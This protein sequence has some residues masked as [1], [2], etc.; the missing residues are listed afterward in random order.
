MFKKILMFTVLF[1]VCAMAQAQ[2]QRINV[3]AFTGSESVS[4][5]NVE[6]VRAAVISAVNASQRFDLLDDAA[7]ASIEE[8]LV[9]RSSEEA[10]NDA[11]ARKALIAIKAN[12][13]LM[14]GNVASLEIKK[15]EKE[16]KIFYAAALN[17][18]VSVTDVAGN[19]TVATKSFSRE[20]TN[21][22]VGGGSIAGLTDAVLNNDTP[23]K[24]V[25]E[26][27]TTIDGDIKKFF[28]E[29]F[30]LLATIYGEDFEIKKDKLVQCYISIGTN[31]GVFNGQMF[32]IFEVKI[33]VGKE[34]KSKIG[35]LKIVQADEDIA[36][37]K[38]TKGDKEVKLAMDRYLENKAV[39]ENATPLIVIS[40]PKKDPLGLGGMAKGL[41]L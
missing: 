27:L 7:W 9:R 19:K 18:S 29:E 21:V 17:Y 39:D 5:E 16:G 4:A 6:K 15:E 37:G 33:K 23:E 3:K 8:E 12:N 14:T 35:S 11:E 32:D 26:V 28:E 40:R 24:A 41:G 2:K 36:L 34:T 38:V 1:A 30:P 25:N 10:V 22:S 20:T 13:F 31:S